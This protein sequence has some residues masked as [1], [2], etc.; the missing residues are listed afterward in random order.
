M[1]QPSTHIIS[2]KT[3]PTYIEIALQVTEVVDTHLSFTRLPV[4]A[5]SKRLHVARYQTMHFC[6]LALFITLQ[7]GFLLLLLIQFSALWMQER[8]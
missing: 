8:A 7:F 5:Q 2:N 3:K 4:T 6:P 1:L